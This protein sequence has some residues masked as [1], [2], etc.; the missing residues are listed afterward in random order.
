MTK[1]ILL[2]TTAVLTIGA[3][4]PAFADTARAPQTAEAQDQGV[5]V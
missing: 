5:L 3:A 2:A 1:T 4:A